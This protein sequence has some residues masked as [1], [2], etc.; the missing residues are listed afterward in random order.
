MAEATWPARIGR[1]EVLGRLG[2]GGM[3]EVLLCRLAGAS[4]FERL[5]TLK[6]VLPS[7]AH[8]PGFTSMFLDEARIVASIRH[9]NVVQVFELL[10]EGGELCIVMEYLEGESLASL[11]ASLR[12][13]ARPFPPALACWILAEAAAG[14]HAAHQLTGPDG[15]S[16]EIIHRD[17][18]PQ[19]IFVTYDGAVKLLDFG[20][21]H[22]RGRITQTE[23]GTIKG[24]LEYMSPEQATGRE[25]DARSDLFSLGVVLWELVTGRSL[26]K[27]PSMLAVARAIVEEP[28]PPPSRLCEVPP[29][30]DAVCLRA[31]SRNAAERYQTAAELRRDVLGL[32]H[33]LAGPTLPGPDSLSPL[34]AEAFASRIAEKRE[35]VR[36]ARSGAQRVAV[37]PVPF[38]E[39][40]APL[41]PAALTPAPSFPPVVSRRRPF[42][43]VG[44]AAVLGAVALLVAQPWAAAPVAA[45][46]P[47]V[48]PMAPSVAE[49]PALPPPATPVEVR[50]RVETSPAGARVEVDGRSVGVSPVEVQ[51]PR[52][53]THISVVARKSGYLVAESRLVPDVDQ[54]LTLKLVAAAR[55]VGPRPKQ[56]DPLDEKW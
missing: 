50:L 26:F 43:V 39:S 29:E 9:A 8:Q 48:V 23:S 32:A 22:S 15:R 52:T 2:A 11:R 16:L 31:L 33:Q 19:N 46:P 51:V 45:L 36:Q 10:D 7:L 14:L 25:L 44:V 17:L 42:V 28:I 49:P 56:P 55:R 4:G 6:R 30:L 38:D 27:R 21:A 37:P 47:P 18:S 34:M 40:P 3:A 35:M 1:Y 5:V 54:K 41:E 13:S 20:I 12:G 24:K 53:A